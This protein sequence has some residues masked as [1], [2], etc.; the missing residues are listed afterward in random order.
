MNFFKKVLVKGFHI[1]DYTY[2]KYR[3]YIRNM[4]LLLKIR[5]GEIKSK[6][7]LFFI[8]D[9]SIPQ[10]GFADRVKA[11]VCAAH[12]A[13][14]SGLQFKIVYNDLEDFL[15]PASRVEAYPDWRASFDDLEY[16]LTKTKIWRLYVKK[17]ML[18][19]LKK[20]GFQYHCYNYN[21]NMLPCQFRNGDYW[22]DEYARL[23]Q[24]SEKL[25][26][27][28]NAVG[29]DKGTYAAVHLRFANALESFEKDFNNALT[30]EQQLLLIVRCK[31]AIAKIIEKGRP[32]VVFSDSKI[33]LNSLGDMDVTVLKSDN[34][35]HIG[36]HD[37]SK[38]VMLKTLLDFYLIAQSAEVYSIGCKE[39]YAN[40][41]FPQVAAMVGN[42]NFFRI[43]A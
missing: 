40:S 5:L 15:I 9:P 31:K 10:P 39:I 12:E 41:G 19:P 22:Y 32:V 11:I 43:Q 28:I 35:G 34:V 29:L 6:D 27:A 2:A 8:I 21:G 33:F 18:P 24:P 20:K 42:I 16:S 30:K 3:D 37:T 13:K 25:Q 23:F 38:D 4:H 17:G 26:S 36:M 1:D 7:V 14:T